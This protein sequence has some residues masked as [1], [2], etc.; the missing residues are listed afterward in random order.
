[1]TVQI[2]TLAN[3]LRV[4]TDSVMSVESVTLGAWIGV[5]TRDESQLAN[6]IA[7]FLEHMVFKGTRRRT[8]YDIA[9]E[10]EAVGGQLNAYTSRENTAFYARVLADDVPL[11]VDT[12]ADILQNSVFD[13]KELQRERQVV[14]Q[15]I[16]QVNDTPDD[17][18][19]DH[20]QERAYFQQAL[21]RPVLG[22]SEVVARLEKGDL[23]DYI[24]LYGSNNIVLTAAGKIRHEDFVRLAEE[25]F[26][27]LN[28]VEV[29]QRQKTLYTGG[30]FREDRKLDQAHFLLGFEGVAFGD[31]DYY[32]ANIYSTLLGGGMSSRLFQDI[33]EQRG[34]VYSIYSFTS[35]FMDSGL[36]GVYA[37]TGE[38]ELAELV[39]AVSD[40]MMKS[41]DDL[42]E[43][44]VERARIQ[45]KASIL[46]GRE[47]TSVRCEQLAQQMLVFG[48]QITTE[49]IVAEIEAVDLEKTRETARRLLSSAPTI[50][51]IGPLSQ[52]ESY[53]AVGQRFAA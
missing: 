39:P 35:S 14:L 1:M 15:E 26:G 30:D 9:E 12:I 34:L 17:V 11:A 10:I 52:L 45:L 16:G 20:F 41:I 5:G 46:M 49:E 31:P 18:I 37:G 48:R 38:K 32:A 27:A 43:A 7:H 51:A 8:A 29:P 50:A 25:H 19:F 22:K 33:R 53:D 42:S 44:E 21:G 40:V 4:A 13:R 28:S 6:G 36:F 2:S 24:S 23:V 47:S 3:G